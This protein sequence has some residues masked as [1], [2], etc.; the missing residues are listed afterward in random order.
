MARIALTDGSGRWFET[1]TSTLYKEMDEERGFGG[2]YE[3]DPRY[4]IRTGEL[5]D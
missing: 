5:A 3:Y 4:F 2:E 1:N